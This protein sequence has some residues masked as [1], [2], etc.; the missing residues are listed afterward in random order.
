[1]IT[2]CSNQDQQLVLNY[3]EGRFGIERHLFEDFIF[4]VA[5][6]GRIF[7][8]PKTLIDNPPPVTAGILIA[9][10]SRSIKPTTNFF[11]LFGKYATKSVIKLTKENALRFI[12]GENLDISADEIHDVVGGY[13]LV[14]YLGFPLG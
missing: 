12:R 14:T 5:S 3:F 7:L 6:K 13:I 2:K 8:G 10:I 1:M 11:Q 9:R 4:Y